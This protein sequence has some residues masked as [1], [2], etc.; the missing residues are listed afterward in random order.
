MPSAWVSHPRWWWWLCACAW[1]CGCVDGGEAAC[2]AGVGSL[3]SW[4]PGLAGSHPQLCCTPSGLCLQAGTPWTAPRAPC[5]WGPPAGRARASGPL[6][7][8]APARPAPTATARAPAT[9]PSAQAAWTSRALAALSAVRG[10]VS[11]RHVSTPAALGVGGCLRGGLPAVC[12][13]HRDGTSRAGRHRR[14]IVRAARAGLRGEEHA[15]LSQIRDPSPLQ[16]TTP[17]PPRAL[18]ATE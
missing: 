12:R 1:V 15:P 3:A 9:T 4:Q 8:R 6:A 2:R 13:A 17:T 7:G 16:L 10:P 11:T 14:R 18:A 5:A